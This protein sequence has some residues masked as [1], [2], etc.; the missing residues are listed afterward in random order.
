[1]NATTRQ[2]ARDDCGAAGEPFM[3]RVAKVCLVVLVVA[4]GFVWLIGQTAPDPADEHR[5]PPAAGQHPPKPQQAKPNQPNQ[6]NGG[7][8]GC[9]RERA[10]QHR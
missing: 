5:P 4:G 1:M 8:E 2:R 9:G 7:G 10:G 3:R 6:P